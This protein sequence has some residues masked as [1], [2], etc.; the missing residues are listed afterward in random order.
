MRGPPDVPP[1]E[2]TPELFESGHLWLQE[3]VVGTP[4]RFRLAESGRLAFAGPDGRFEEPPPSLRH[5]VG[6]VRKR[7]DR[8]ALL[9]AA[10]DPSAV[11]FHGV[12]TRNEG[13]PYDWSRLPG[14]LGTDVRSTTSGGTSPRSSDRTSVPRKPGRRDQS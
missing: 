8:D 14:F 5:A 7:L 4:L 13:V 9:S 6:H 3:L 12:A 2:A 10:D 11:V 1:A